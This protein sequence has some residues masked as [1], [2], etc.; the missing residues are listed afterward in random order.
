MHDVNKRDC[1]WVY[2][3][4]KMLFII[5][6]C[7][8]ILLMCVCVCAHV[9]AF[10]GIVCV[11]THIIAFQEGGGGRVCGFCVC[12][13][14]TV[15]HVVVVIHK[16]YFIRNW[17]ISITALSIDVKTVIL[18]YYFLIVCYMNKLRITALSQV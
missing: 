1:N 15:F 8:F 5:T 17:R 13:D 12:G 16:T 4:I 9:F 11:C 10:G 7:A 18:H 6:F 2:I 14:T 3:I